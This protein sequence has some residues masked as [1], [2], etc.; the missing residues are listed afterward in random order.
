LNKYHEKGR[1]DGFISLGMNRPVARILA[2]LNNQEEVT[3]VV[4][5]TGTGLLQP[6]VT[7]AMRQVKEHD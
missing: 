5:E 7:I 3:S 1:V 6:E 4:L 2:Y